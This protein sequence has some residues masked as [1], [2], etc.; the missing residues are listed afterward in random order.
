MPR[1]V[2]HLTRVSSPVLLA[3]TA[4]LDALGR[5][6][7]NPPAVAVIE[8]EAGVG[9]TR[10]VSEL[11]GQVRAQGGRVLIGHCHP[12]HDPFPL[13]P[14]VEA[15]RGLGDDVGTMALSPLG[16]ALRP[17][18]PE[19]AD[20]LPP[21]PE[22]LGDRHM[23]RH[24]L[25]RA[26]LELFGALGPAL[27][28]LED[29]HWS[30]EATPQ[31]LAF[32][33][34][35]QPPELGLVLTVRTEGPGAPP[36]LGALSSRQ[37]AT[38]SM[39]RLRLTPLDPL[40]VKVM[41]G[42]ILE[43]EHVSDEFAAYLHHRTA[44]IP[45]A[46]EEVLRLLVDRKDIVRWR[47][48]WARRALEQVEVPAAIRDSMLERVGRLSEEARSVVEA[49]A[50]MAE[51]SSEQVLAA[52]AAL[53]AGSASAVLSEAVA[54]GI[55]QATG[56]GYSCRHALAAQAVYDAVVAPKRRQL[57]YR[58][59]EALEAERGRVK[60]AGPPGAAR[61][62]HHWREAGEVTRWVHF[63]E[64][65]ARLASALGDP[66][67]ATALL[68]EAVGA[69]GIDT[70]TRARLGFDLSA[71]AVDSLG[72]AE[73]ID[74]VRHVLEAEEIPPLL[75][76]HL[77]AG[78]G[79][80][81]HQA[82]D[83]SGARAQFAAAVPDM[84]DEPLELAQLLLALALPWVLEGDLKDHLRWLAQADDLTAA[85]EDGSL[86]EV[87]LGDR[88]TILVAIG[89]A[90][91]WAAVPAPPPPGS[92]MRLL[93]DRAR[94]CTN[95]A[96]NAFYLGHHERAAALVEEGL[97]ISADTGYQRMAPALRTASLLLA[98]ANGSWEGLEAA[99]ED[100]VDHQP[101]IPSL[102]Q[103][104]TVLGQLALAFGRTDDA[105]P[106][107]ADAV[108]RAA[109]CGALP[110]LGTAAA[111]LARLCLGQGDPEGARVLVGPPLEIL[112]A[113]GIWAWGT[114][115][116]PVAVATLLACD[117]ADEA[118]EVCQRFAAGLRGRDAP[119]AVAALSACEATVLEASGR[120]REGAEGFARAEAAWRDVGRP[121]DEALAAEG[122]ARCLLRAADG[123]GESQSEAEAAGRNALAIFQRLGATWDEARVG[124]VL[125]EHDVSVPYQRRGGRRSYGEELS[126]R[127]REV[128]ELA[129]DGLTSTRIAAR[130]FLSPR[131]VD[132]HL[133]R[134]LRKLGMASRK[135]LVAAR[136][137]GALPNTK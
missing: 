102:V 135:E 83:A 121:Y 50:V 10:L 66:A 29:L 26:L 54:A 127:E 89:D 18:F 77:R 35:Q 9:K 68:L 49:A 78:L 65:A 87:L 37:P 31:F 3:R 90:D 23:E 12:L 119:A 4:E 74:A 101:D 108:G 117:E 123:A 39:V 51:P 72:Q 40:D 41:V 131:T 27:V 20:R 70:G 58:A 98:W 80:L 69:S 94:L 93:Q 113:K 6:I 64:E 63:A 11:A 134:A 110:T 5:A 120:L 19:L 15:V 92:A 79:A 73:A 99:A 46:V 13:G 106:L 130:L 100:V 60:G 95:L 2:T 122:R 109:R 53:S 28:V 7:A 129:A 24:R 67:T 75:R 38:T 81:L 105:V 104:T 34:D 128:V 21:P 57:H 1:G 44:G 103:A 96:I 76:G 82:G 48:Q 22:P 25:W 52:V 16:G 42:A 126:P 59:A 107:L 71:A 118:D 32:L 115:L 84:V 114:G 111:S 125:R 36:V 17:V 91:G 116:L 47:G 86:R 85:L 132:H 45:L 61:L 88:A 14:V 137:A 112:A 136:D 33:A 97:R 55:L 124:R 56:D 8:G 62:A 133:A 30:D 43:T